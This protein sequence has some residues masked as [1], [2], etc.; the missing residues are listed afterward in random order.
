MG[1]DW[2][3]KDN[4]SITR[5]RKTTR[6]YFIIIPFSNWILNDNNETFW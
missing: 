5:I 2:K 1:K 4:D 3:T 6:K